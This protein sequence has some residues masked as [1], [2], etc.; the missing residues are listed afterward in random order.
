MNTKAFIAAVALVSS[1]LVYAQEDGPSFRLTALP[2]TTCFANTHADEALLRRRIEGLKNTSLTKAVWVTCSFPTVNLEIPPNDDIKVA[3][4]D[5]WVVTD[6]AR[7]TMPCKAGFNIGNPAPDGDFIYFWAQTTTNAERRGWLHIEPDT[8]R[9]TQS[10][11]GITCKIP[12][13]STLGEI[14]V[15]IL[16]TDFIPME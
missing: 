5:M 8:G 11:F 10:S 9:F 14:R 13:A 1:G 15:R 7:V 16:Q 4:I 2:S 6:L 12:Q 3:S